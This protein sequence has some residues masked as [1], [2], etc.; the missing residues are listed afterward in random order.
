[1]T[2]RR[3]LIEV[4]KSTHC[5]VTRPEVD[6][7]VAKAVRAAGDASKVEITRKGGCVTIRTLESREVPG[8]FSAPAPLLPV[9]K[10]S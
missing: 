1:V 5:H 8:P 10:D 7:H 4:A 2:S 3:R 6:E 9:A